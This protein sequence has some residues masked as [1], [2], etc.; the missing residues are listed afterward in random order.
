MLDINSNMLMNTYVRIARYLLQLSQETAQNEV[1]MLASEFC[2][3]H[4]PVDNV[5]M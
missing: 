1:R 3:H 4:A 2:G 5:A